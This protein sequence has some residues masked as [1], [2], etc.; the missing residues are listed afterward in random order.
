MLAMCVVLVHHGSMIIHLVCDAQCVGLESTFAPARF[1]IGEQARGEVT[2]LVE[3]C[4]GVGQ[5]HQRAGY[6]EDEAESRPLQV[7]SDDG[8]GIAGEGVPE[9]AK[10]RNRM[11][12][13]RSA[14]S[15]SLTDSIT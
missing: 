7:C 11:M 5:L 2:L 6:R 9:K 15:R 4:L 3:G 1:S 14:C 8:G 10:S 13:V 12:L